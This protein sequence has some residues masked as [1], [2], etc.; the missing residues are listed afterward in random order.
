MD[1]DE[2][3]ALALSRPADALT[4]ARDVLA[5]SPS[6]ADAAVAHQAAGVVHRD[7]GD[8]DEAVAE[9]KLAYR[10]AHRAADADREAE[11]LASLGV[12]QVM[13]GH[14]ERGLAALD[15]VVPGRTGVLAGRI[16]IRRVWALAQVGRNAE[17]LDDAERAVALLS[18]TGDLVWEAR[19]LTH[20]AMVLLAMGVIDRADQDYALSEELFAQSGQQVEYADTRQARG[21]AAF[22]R[23]D[24]PVAL[25]FLDDA[26]KVVEELGVLEPDLYVN[27]CRVLLAAGLTH[28]A[29]TEINS[30]LDRIEQ[31]RGST[32]RRAE[33]LYCAALAAHAA[34][35]L[36]LAENRSRDALKMFRRQQRP[37]WA[38]R[39]ELALLQSRYAAGERTAPLLR[40]GKRV[41]AELDS[42]DPDLAAEAHL[43]TGRL[44]L[45]R[46]DPAEARRHLKVAAGARN[47]GLQTRGTGWLAQATLHE[48]DG[49]SRAM[50]ASCRQGLSLIEIYLRTLGATE[51]RVLAT[52]EGAELAAIALRYAVQR[53]DARQ[54]LE[55]S[56]R[57]RATVLA[58]PPV[59]PQADDELVGELAALRSLTQRLETS[60][61]RQLGPGPLQ[62]ERRRLESAVRRRVLHTRGTTGERPGLFRSTDLLDRLGDRSLVELTQVDEQL[63]A[64]VAARGRVR[65]LPVGPTAQATHSLSHALFALRREATGRGTHR[66]D[67]DSIGARL[68]RALLGDVVKHLGDG[69][70]VIVPTG[71]L[72][73][74][75]WSLLPSLRDRPT[76]VTPSAAAWLRARTAV[77][78]SADRVVLIGGPQLSTGPEEVRRLSKLYPDALVLAGGDAKAEAVLNAMDGASLVHVAAHGTFRADSPLFS[79][80]ELDDGPLTV[81]DLERLERAP[82]RVVL[83]SCSSAVGGPGGADELLGLVSALVA[84]GSAGV[85]AS[86]VP[87]NDPATVPL[88]LGLHVRLRAGDDLAE[89]LAKARASA[90]DS[91][92]A[93]TAAESFIALG[94]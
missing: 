32:T 80:L 19:A 93:R 53:G 70:V 77:P 20:R 51:L 89:A 3:L 35:A 85:V 86:V 36:D 9:L 44:A 91:Q 55:W 74:V 43:F 33:L 2:L 24:L 41:S 29:L 18:D 30:A 1:G 66:L 60:T 38:A 16:L 67:L 26:Q 58:I 15:S 68:E 40:T 27:K 78:P 61:D 37:W 94:A 50:L 49:R 62:R 88:M 23:G 69:P 63:Y 12:A 76:S 21:A 82:H 47:R 17:A 11:I 64:V 34:G 75:P 57:W 13:A 71:R 31:Q 8:I 28:D 4:I 92:M 73:A 46:T 54:V 83:S 56:E 48:A 45:A 52:A 72:H 42:L 79:A 90:G 14:T 22:A 7:F 81:Y 84:L 39:A 65:L 6:D 87:V 25:Q 59:R 10:H 5:N